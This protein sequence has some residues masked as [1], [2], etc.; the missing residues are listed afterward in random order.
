MDNEMKNIY[1]MVDK[2][3]SYKGIDSTRKSIQNMLSQSLSL[4]VEFEKRGE[5][6][7]NIPSHIELGYVLLDYINTVQKEMRDERISKILSENRKILNFTEFSF[8]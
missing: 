3:I 4:K 5:P 8:F 6:M 2:M 1:N 7:I